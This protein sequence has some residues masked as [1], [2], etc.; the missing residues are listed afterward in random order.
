MGFKSNKKQS[1][2]DILYSISEKEKSMD[3]EKKDEKKENLNLNADT[4]PK[5]QEKADKGKNYD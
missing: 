2:R 5:K 4:N 1:F 3:K